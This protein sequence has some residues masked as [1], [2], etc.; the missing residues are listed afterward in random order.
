MNRYPVTNQVRELELANYEL[1]EMLQEIAEE[2]ALVVNDL[3][4]HRDDILPPKEIAVYK[5]ALF[6]LRGSA[7][8]QERDLK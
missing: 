5:N 7:I 6:M 2:Y 4:E 8:D 3:R 1:A